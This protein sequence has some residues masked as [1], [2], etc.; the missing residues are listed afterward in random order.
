MYHGPPDVLL[1]IDRIKREQGNAMLARIVAGCSAVLIATSGVCAAA[2]APAIR[3]RSIPPA[4]ATY[5]TIDY[6][7][8][9][10]TNA[11]GVNR[12]G[13]LLRPVEVVGAF[14]DIRGTHGFLRSG[15]TFT[16]LDVPLPYAYATEA[17]GINGRHQ[18]VGTY[19][20]AVSGNTCDFK[21]DRGTYTTLGLGSCRT[22]SMLAPGFQPQGITGAGEI[23]GEHYVDNGQNGV[24]LAGFF[25]TGAGLQGSA[26]RLPGDIQAGLFGINSAHRLVG[27]SADANQGLH[28][29]VFSGP[30]ATGTQLDVPFTSQG[31]VA[32]GVNDAGL[33]TGSYGVDYTISDGPY[34]VYARMYGAHGFVDDGG[35]FRRLDYPGASRTV[36]NGINNLDP[37]L[38]GRYDVVGTYLVGS[39]EHGYLASISPAAASA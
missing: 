1:W 35:V 34:G 23:A 38:V 13:P 11:Y 36:A 9:S 22:S 24:R 29:M 27:F 17:F 19:V 8:A 21:Y 31:T 26:Y 2:A 7:G 18:I 37:M 30:S 6:P 14:G 28:G 20:D 33:I 32:R 3:V 10:W 39:A 16:E 12:S 4:N 15:R 25:A 5:T